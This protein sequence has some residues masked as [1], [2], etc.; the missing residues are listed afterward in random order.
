MME[1]HH[2]EEDEMFDDI[3]GEVDPDKKDDKLA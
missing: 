1:K 3:R 2:F